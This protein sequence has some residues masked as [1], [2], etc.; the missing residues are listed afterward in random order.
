M[1]SFVKFLIKRHSCLTIVTLLLTE[2]V[3]RVSF[4]LPPCAVDLV[5]YMAEANKK[6]PFTIILG[7]FYD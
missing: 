4:S 6:N 7:G 5:R 2:K 3:Q 1:K